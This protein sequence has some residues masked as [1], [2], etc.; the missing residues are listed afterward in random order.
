MYSIMMFC[1]I[2]V[3]SYTAFETI[4]RDDLA[5]INST[6]STFSQITLSSGLNFSGL[7]YATSTFYE[8]YFK[9]LKAAP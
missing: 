5:A 2:L 4:Q 1:T 8:V 6:M 7:K 9:N 3:N